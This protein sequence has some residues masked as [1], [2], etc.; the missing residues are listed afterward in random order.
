MNYDAVLKDI[1]KNVF[2]TT[3]SDEFP[4]YLV[5]FGA[6]ASTSRELQRV[7]DKCEKLADVSRPT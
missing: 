7:T 3:K 6:Q 4:A 1:M 2:F 5:N